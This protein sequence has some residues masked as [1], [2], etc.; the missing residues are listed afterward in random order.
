M[1]RRCEKPVLGF[2]RRLFTTSRHD[3]SHAS[4]PQRKYTG[5]PASTIKRPGQV[6]GR[7]F[8]EISKSSAMEEA[9]TI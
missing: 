1:L 9:A 6:L 3:H 7:V 2:I 8:A 4:L 5:T